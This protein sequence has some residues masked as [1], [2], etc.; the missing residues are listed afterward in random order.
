VVRTLRCFLWAWSILVLWAGASGACLGD[1]KISGGVEPAYTACLSESLCSNLVRTQFRLQYKPVSVRGFSLRVKL[2]RA[3]Q[4]TMDDDKDDGS[5]EEEQASKFDPPFDVMDVK[6]RFSQ[7]DGRDRLE[8]RTGY[9]YQ[10]SDP[11][12]VDGYH[13]TYL[14]GDYYFGGA[15]RS[16]WGGLSRRW[17][18]LLKV[19]DN[20]Y[21]QAGRPS[22]ELDQFVSTYTAP[23]NVDGTTR[24]YASYARELRF[25]GSNVVRTPSNRFELGAT[26]NPTRWLE[27]YARVSEFGTRGIPGAARAVAGIDVTI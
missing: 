8:I 10:H 15:I 12:T 7:P 19:S 27:L 11:N 21:A 6:L 16:G 22:E 23:L 9:A 24:I 4:M 2:S 18:V 20:L 5:S 14:S 1:A 26:R 25:S 17:D 3:Y 13:T